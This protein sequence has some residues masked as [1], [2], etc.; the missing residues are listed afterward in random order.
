[1]ISGNH[2]YYNSN[3][4]DTDNHIEDIVKSYNNVIYLNNKTYVDDE[5]NL[6]IGSTL[7]SNIPQ[8][9]NNYIQKSINDY[10]QIENLTPSTTSSMFWNNLL[11]IEQALSNGTYNKIIVI[12]HHSPLLR[13]TSNLHHRHL[14]TIYAY[15]NNL[16]YLM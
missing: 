3:I 4:K 13:E 2:E 7:W 14:K 10:H 5:N 8:E 1:L 12:T 15:G 6:Y 16:G 11:F 9:Y